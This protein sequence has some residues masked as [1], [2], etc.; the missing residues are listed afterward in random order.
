MLLLFIV[1]PNINGQYLN[2]SSILPYQCLRK[3]MK[4]HFTSLDKL[5]MLSS[6]QQR[7]PELSD[8]MRKLFPSSSVTS[9]C[10][11]LSPVCLIPAG[12]IMPEKF[13]ICFGILLNM[14][15]SAKVTGNL[16]WA[17]LKSPV[18]LGS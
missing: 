12:T 3:T 9:L 1:S 2:I 18:Y 8:K 11:H 7:N 17:F 10:H 4:M 13:D 14:C 15:C 6:L 5:S 16:E